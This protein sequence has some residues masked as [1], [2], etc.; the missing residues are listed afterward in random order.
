MRSTILC[1]ARS[2]MICA[3]VLSLGLAFGM[4]KTNAQEIFAQNEMIPESTAV[5]EMLQ[6]QQSATTSA[7]KNVA[8]YF[9]KLPALRARFKMIGPKG[10]LSTGRFY[11]KRPDRMRFLYVTPTQQVITADSKWLS[12]QE[13]PKLE[14]NRY[15]IKSSPI[16]Q[17]LSERKKLD[18]T[19]MLSDVSLSED[20]VVLTLQDPEKPEA[21]SL[22]LVFAY[23]NIR[24]AGWQLI[25]VQDQ[26]TQIYLNEIEV[27]EDLPNELF[28]VDE[29]AKEFN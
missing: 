16:G 9:D 12:I 20:R 29:S 4:R 15:P 25:D 26:L 22:S 21:G 10:S 13:G 14:A 1:A 28:F 19:D 8:V 27:L 6:A 5:Q 3:S 24:L 11:F 2:V 23:P 17:F 7:L 18:E